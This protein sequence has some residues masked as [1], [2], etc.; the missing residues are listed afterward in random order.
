MYQIYA[1]DELIYDSGSSEYK[2]GKGA[3]SLEVNK[4]G[5]F[6]FSVYSDHFYY[7]RFVKLK[8][9]V[10][11]KKSGRILF[12]GRVFD[13]QVGYWKE[14]ILTCEGEMG[15][16][17]DSI[18]RPYDFS[19]TPSF[20]LKKFLDEHNAQVDEFKKFKPGRVTV[21]DQN[22]YI[23]RSNSAYETTLSNMN[24]RLIE[25]STGGYLH[26]TH[27]DDDTDPVPT[28][29][30]LADFER[31]S[32]QTIEFGKNLRDFVKKSSGQEI[33]TAIIPLG[34]K[35][36]DDS[37]L[38]IVSVNNGVD[39]VYD[40]AAVA[41]YGWVF[42]VVEWDDVT[43]PE[44]LKTKS[45][46]YLKKSIQESITLELNAVDMHL[47]DRSIDSFRLGDYVRVVS[48]PHNFYEELLCTRMTFD[49]LK[50]ENDTVVLGGSHSGF[51]AMSAKAASE[52]AKVKTSIKNIGTSGGGGSSSG[53]S[54]DSLIARS[55]GVF[56][57]EQVA[58]NGSTVYYLHDKMTLEES[59]NIWRM[60]AGV[61][62]VS[63]DGGQTWSAGIDAEGNAVLNMLSVIGIDT[64][65]LNV[66]NLTDISDDLG[67]WTIDADGLHGVMDYDGSIRYVD[68]Y[69]PGN[70]SWQEDDPVISY[71]R[72]NKYD[73][74]KIP[75]L[76]AT[77]GG[78]VIVTTSGSENKRRTVIYRDGIAVWDDDYSK[79][80]PLT[81][82]KASSNDSFSW[83]SE[84]RVDRID[85]N[86]VGTMKMDR[87]ATRATLELQGADGVKKTL[88][89][90]SGII[91]NI[92]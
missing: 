77:A 43:L 82:F 87:S 12:R 83:K 73:G 37:R 88:D 35:T 59:T 48:P 63:S 13:E 29:N 51:A 65:W 30:Y 23:A 6:T 62:S 71:G 38:T 44:N 47:L 90:C 69:C 5:S 91:T 27:G 8:T 39:Y 18:I 28:L 41:L 75:T 86:H 33:A 58:E 56:K 32:T 76:T 42:K 49:I 85:F 68:I 89:I 46:V 34:A 31:V 78:K 84:L 55:F 57:T 16:F 19:G 14:K 21:V 9:V 25:D 26:I 80:S 50:P 74:T 81:Y 45:L 72:L 22:N 79:I 40:E 66:G 67:G 36:G 17:Q 1:D 4:S 70:T 53:G 64:K 15:F 20:L 3:G 11:V 92:S 61:F 10:V 2:I 54:L 52:V 60:S 24:S 7:D